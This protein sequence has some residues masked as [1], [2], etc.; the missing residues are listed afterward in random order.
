[1]APIARVFLWLGIHK[2]CK[3]PLKLETR[4]LNGSKSLLSHL[5]LGC[6]LPGDISGIPCVVG[7]FMISDLLNH[8]GSLLAITNH[9]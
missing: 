7:Y 6:L 1:M 3:A 4:V 2:V 5:I 8:A 9:H